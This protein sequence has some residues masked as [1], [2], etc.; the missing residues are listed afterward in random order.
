M[1]V[2]VR[3]CMQYISKSYERILIKL[4]GGIDVTQGPVSYILVADPDP[5][6]LVQNPDLG[7]DPDHF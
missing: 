6:F 7:G 2:C 4:F 1:C 3:V 5:G